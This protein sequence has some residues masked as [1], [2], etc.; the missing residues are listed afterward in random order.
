MKPLF[1]ALSHYAG[2]PFYDGIRGSRRNILI[3]PEAW[4]KQFYSFLNGKKSKEPM[5][6]HFSFFSKLYFQYLKLS[7]IN[8]KNMSS[9]YFFIYFFHN[10][11]K[12][13]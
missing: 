6:M 13:F 1:A 11:M 2:T 9:F 3:L 4:L 12:L 7:C 10:C 8:L 5:D